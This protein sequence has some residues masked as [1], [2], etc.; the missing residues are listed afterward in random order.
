MI[1]PDVNLLIYAFNASAPQHELALRWWTGLLNSQQSVGVSWPV[2][3][4]FLRI[5]TNARVVAEPYTISEALGFVDEWWARP[6][7]TRL[8]PTD[9][10][11]GCFRS[12]CLS[13]E[14]GGTLLTDAWIAAYAIAYSGTLYTNDTDF[15]RF[16]ELRTRNPLRG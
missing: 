1:V 9:A 11:Y 2:F 8:V 3:Q 13:H 12:L 6:N 4:G 16:P 5:L 10:V 15:Q 7:V 14:L